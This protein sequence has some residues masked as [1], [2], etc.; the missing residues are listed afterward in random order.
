MGPPGVDGLPGK[1]GDNGAKGPQVIYAVE[2]MRTSTL[3]CLFAV[4]LSILWSTI[5]VESDYF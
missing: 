5:L 3:G 1:R 2:V 4:G